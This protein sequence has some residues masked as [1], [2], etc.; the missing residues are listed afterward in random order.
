MNPTSLLFLA[1]VFF[2]M[3]AVVAYLAKSMEEN[4]K[5]PPGSSTPAA[6]DEVARLRRDLQSGVLMVEIDGKTY[7]APADL[8]EQQRHLLQTA[9]GDLRGWVDLELGAPPAA[10]DRPAPDAEAPSTQPPISVAPPTLDAA[11]IAPAS[12]APDEPP[13]RAGL[14][15]M[16]ARALE[17]DVPKFRQSLSMVAQIDAILQEKL[18]PTPLANRGIALKENPD[19]SLVVWIGLEKYAAID[20]IPDEAIRQAIK[21]SVAEWTNRN[22]S[23]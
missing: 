1:A 7:R 14:A 16:L 23:T 19:H 15:T 8:P 3:G 22:L 6:L 21:D 11:P 12:P 10:P 5:P 2:S 20:A 17:A 18:K 13:K 4:K 9:L